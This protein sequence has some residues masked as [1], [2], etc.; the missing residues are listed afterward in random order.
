M[1]SGATELNDADDLVDALSPVVRTLRD[2][3]I[4]HFLG[5]RLRFSHVVF[6]SDSPPHIDKGDT[7]VSRR[8]ARPRIRPNRIEDGLLDVPPPL[9]TGTT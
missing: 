8:R 2:L 9:W 4:P 7:I 5:D 3:G 6:Q 1:E